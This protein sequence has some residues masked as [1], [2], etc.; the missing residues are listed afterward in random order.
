[1]PKQ[2]DVLLIGLGNFGLSWATHIIPHCREEARLCGVVDLRE[3]R[4]A[5][6]DPAI[7]RFHTAEE[8]LDHVRPDL[9]I[10][11]TPPDVH[12]PLNTLLLERSL[13]V[14][15]EKPIANSLASAAQMAQVLQH[16][17]GFL[18][19]AENYRYHDIFRAV[20]ALLE[21]GQMGQLH[22]ISCHFCHEHPDYSMF[23]HGRLAHPLLEDVTIHHLDV[24]RYLSSQEPLNVWCR[25]YPAPYCWYGQRP[26]SAHILSDMTGGCVFDYNGTLAAPQSTTP[27]NGNWELQCDHGVVEIRDNRIYL[28]QQSQVQEL[29]TA[30]TSE[31]SRIPMLKEACRALLEGRPGE[32]DFADNLHSFRWMHLAIQ[33]AETGAVIPIHA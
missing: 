21:S 1:M 16:T 4:W 23:Y 28:H 15:C 17:G 32:T 24:A 11:V 14:L 6:V 20:R 30:C 8:A 2:L 25:E 9:V 12:T 10:N 26:A 22:R 18:M 33:S 19:I 27:W 5:Q 31:D 3:E 13:P 7:P 29:P